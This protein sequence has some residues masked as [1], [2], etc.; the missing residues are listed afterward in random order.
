MTPLARN[1]IERTAYRWLAGVAALSAAGTL[2]LPGVLHGPAAMNGSARGTALVLLV[3]GVPL[4]LAASAGRTG[5]S[6]PADRIVMVGVLAYVTYQALLFPFATPFNELFLL[7]VVLLSSSLATLAI[8]VRGTDVAAAGQAFRFGRASRRIA[9]FVAVVAAA[10]ALIWLGRI[11]PALTSAADPPFLHG[12]GL[13]TN[14]V[15]VQD[16]AIWLPLCALGA[17]LLWREQAWGVVLTGAALSMWTVESLSIAVDQWLGAHS[18]PASTVVSSSLVVPFVVL[19]ALC[20]V[21][22][23]DFLRCYARDRTPSPHR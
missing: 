15:F 19:A 3:I 20:V 9:V 13:T 23:G 4:L 2:F 8:A 22:L 10:N 11:V 21:V 5:L 1:R 14:P 18:D 16:L 17:A 7:Y 6:E 12:T